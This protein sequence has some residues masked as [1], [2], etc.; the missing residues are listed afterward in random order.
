MLNKGDGTF[1]TPVS[2]SSGGYLAQSVVV[3]DVN[4]DGKL[5]LVVVN[6][7]QYS[8]NCQVGYG[9]GLIGVLLGNGNGTFQPVVTYDSGGEFAYFIAIGDLNHDGKLDLVVTNA[10]QC[11]GCNSGG[12]VS[13]LLGN[14]NGTFEAPVVVYSL[15]QFPAYSVA[16][17][18]VNGD[19][20]P[21][22]FVGLYVDG[23]AVLLGN[24]DGT[25]TSS[26]Y[27]SGGDRVSSM[28]IGDVNG[29]GKADLVLVNSDSSSVGVL[30]GNGDGTFQPVTNYLSGGQGEANSV[31]VGDLNG[32]GKPDLAVANGGV[33]VL[34]NNNGAPPTTISL[35]SSAAPANVKQSVTYTATVANSSAGPLS[36]TVTFED[37][38]TPLAIVPLASNQATYTTS[39]KTAGIHAITGAYS[40]ELH[41]ALGS[42]SAILTEYVRSYN[43]TVALVT[44]GT[45]SLVGQPVTFTATVTSKAGTIP[46][47]ELVTF[48]D[49]TTALTSVALAGGKAAYTT[50]TLSVKGHS[51]K[52][53]YVG[54]NRFKPSTGEVVQR[55]ELYSS[56]TTLSSI[57]NPSTHGQ[58][59]TLTATVTSSAPGGPTGQVIF[60]NGAASVGR[61]MLSA[62]KATFATAKLPV[63][64]LT[65]TSNYNGD[66]HSA[67]SSGETTQTVQ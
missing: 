29:D 46:A 54:D 21:D 66:T 38:P 13:V 20:H 9:G 49:G 40:G 17:A 33:G 63:G 37:G 62:G 8:T 42:Q 60:K 31:A 3:G 1:Q 53:T 18:D 61:A 30:A 4:G 7:C 50:S 26:G 5:D 59:V 47:G 55:V 19:G 12:I 16:I 23:L 2:Y 24:G 65:I 43:S 44:S 58:A 25:F 14:G 64:T 67:K 45:P 27:S 22:L 10:L 28:V 48:Y 39:Y 57:P 52:A 51:I 6:T 56:T 34:L 32:D 11:F 41:I 36:G 35:V 15:N